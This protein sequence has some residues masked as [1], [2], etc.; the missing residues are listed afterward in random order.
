MEKVNLSLFNNILSLCKT[1]HWATYSHRTHIALDQAYDDF[2]ELFDKFVEV[3]LGIYTREVITVSPIS[4][5]TVDDREI[6][7]YIS[8]EFVA[9][10]NELVKIVGEFSQLQSIYDEIKGVENQLLYRLTSLP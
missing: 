9:F 10:N 3:A 8:D 2:S 6:P 1:L 4:L 5:R 7:Q